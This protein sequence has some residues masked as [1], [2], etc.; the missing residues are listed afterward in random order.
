M[1]MQLTFLS[2]YWLNASL[3]RTI[4]PQNKS[5]IVMQ[6]NHLYL[7]FNNIE[8]EKGVTQILH[9]AQEEHL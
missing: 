8:G 9:P 1:T 5:V 3:L 4:H 7:E 2:V 6:K